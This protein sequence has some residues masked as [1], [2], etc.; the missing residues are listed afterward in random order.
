MTEMRQLEDYVNLNAFLELK[1]RAAGKFCEAALDADTLVEELEEYGPFAPLRKNFCE[2]LG[3]GESTLTGWL[4]SGRVPRTAKVA[5]VLLVGVNVLQAEVKRLRR[6]AHELKIIQDG[7]TFQV[8]RFDADETGVSIGK[9][10]ARDI[11]SAKTARVLAGS[12]KAFRMLQETRDVIADMLERT[13]NDRWIEYLQDFD[14]RIIKETL[15][16]FEP[17]KYRE[18]FRPFDLGEFTP[19]KIRERAEA[20]ADVEA[21]IEA[22]ITL[23][24]GSEPSGEVSVEVERK[25]D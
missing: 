22:H 15:A 3:I 13:E 12:V 10:V 6:D 4:K 17:D 9:V 23:E 18:L 25:R 20:R 16:A 5:Y 21:N 8:V 7:G 24:S 11:P 2:F 1:P 14:T 19:D